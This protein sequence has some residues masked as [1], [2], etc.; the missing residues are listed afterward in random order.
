MS[1]NLNRATLAPTDLRLLIQAGCLLTV[2]RLGLW[3]LP[4][5]TLQ[6]L[7]DA[8]GRTHAAQRGVPALPVE[9][10]GWIV[11]AASRCIPRATCL[12]QA[13]VAKTLLCRYGHTARMCIGVAMSHTNRLD[14]HAWVESN[15]QIIVGG[16]GSRSRYKP[17][18]S[19]EKPTQ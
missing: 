14:A 15:G 4:F 9:K 12:T 17:L 18:S 6:R 16:S 19:P 13:L 10:I 7:L 11:S 8:F 5:P 2:V 3:F 1:R